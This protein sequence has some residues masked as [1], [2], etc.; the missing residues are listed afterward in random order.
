MQEFTRSLSHFSK[1][2]I[3]SHPL[4]LSSF[5]S[6]VLANNKTLYPPPSDTYLFLVLYPINFQCMKKISIKHITTGLLIL[7]IMSLIIFPT[8]LF[9]SSCISV[10]VYMHLIPPPPTPPNHYKSLSHLH[11]YHLNINFLSHFC[12]SKQ[13]F[14]SLPLSSAFHNYLL[15]VTTAAEQECNSEAS[16]FIEEYSYRTARP[17]I[18]VQVY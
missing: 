9:L 17:I 3:P 7:K 2:L 15:C 13:P 12:I 1:R 5:P 6:S 18:Q 4:Y 16:F 10:C 14:L 8:T 11:S